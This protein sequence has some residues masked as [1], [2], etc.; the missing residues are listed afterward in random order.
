MI[1][2]HFKTAQILSIPVIILA[3]IASAGGLF[4]DGLYRDNLFVTSA[5]KGNDLITLFLVVPLLIS[6]LIKIKRGSQREI[7]LWMGLL[8][9]MLYNFA[10]YLFG[11]AFN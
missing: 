1:T 11:A 3:A 6:A 5:W 9:Y 7:L 8:D 4:L 10:F 2:Q